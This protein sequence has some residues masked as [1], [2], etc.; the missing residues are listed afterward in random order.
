[1]AFPGRRPAR[2][3]EHLLFEQ[4]SRFNVYQLVRL[5][6]WRDSVAQQH[7]TR[8]VNTTLLQSQ[9][10]LSH[11]LRY[12][13]R[14]GP[15]ASRSMG[16]LTHRLRFRAELSAAFPGHEV[17]QC[18]LALRPAADGKNLD[19][20]VEIRTPNYCIASELG[21]FPETFVEWI[22]D[23]QR[24][25][26]ST[27]AEFLDLF[28]HRFN[29]LR[30]QLKATQD[31]ALNF[32]HPND[33]LQA[34]FLAA[35]MGLSQP[36]LEQQIPLPRRAWLGMASMLADTRHSTVA[37]LRVLRLYLGGT[38]WLEPLIGSWSEIDPA[39]CTQLGTFQSRLGQ[40]LVLGRRVWD[41]QAG[42]RLTLDGIS[43]ERLCALLPSNQA[44]PDGTQP[45]AALVSMLH[46]LFDRR[47]DC[48]IRLA[49][50]GSTLPRA[51]L[52]S[53]PTAMQSQ[54]F[55]LDAA[56]NTA[57]PAYV[58]MQ[59]GRTAWLA[60]STAGDENRIVAYTISAYPNAMNATS[61]TGASG[62][63]V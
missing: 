42:V 58:G 48:H 50:R 47:V 51:I 31:V 54:A 52:A 22:R 46:L 3:L 55:D 60:G 30:H 6:R 5:L 26:D 24:S 15:T 28:N 17:T 37:A 16:E 23:L 36:A 56:D 25:G 32:V 63:P 1:M 57:T 13:L 20:V 10:L 44:M 18:R 19:E 12:R 38:V 21:P 8:P 40:G 45:Y 9:H 39:D 34:D 14:S 33:T 41:Q 62:S 49:V 43:Y 61:A 11:A 27:Q 4:S 35:L 29:V 7:K 53:N 2:S 59:L